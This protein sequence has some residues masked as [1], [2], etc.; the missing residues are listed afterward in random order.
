MRIAKFLSQCGIASRRKSEELIR[1]GRV[2]IN[3][4]KI[5]DPANNIDPETDQITF[6]GKVVELPD[7]HLTLAYHKPPEVIVS[8]D[9]PQGRTTIYEELP[10]E[11]Q[12]QKDRL[13]YAG[14]LDYLS[15]GL[16]ILSTDGNLINQLSHPSKGCEKR[17]LVD[18]DHQ[19]TPEDRQKCLKGV[20]ESGELLKCLDIFPLAE[21][22]TSVS[23]VEIWPG[24]K[25]DKKGN[26]ISLTLGEG[27]NRHI[28]RMLRELNYRIRRLQRFSVGGL[29]IEG[30]D[31]GE[32]KKLDQTEIHKLFEF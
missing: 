12:P 17:Y 10:A 1:A 32:W 4:Q 7:T 28:R 18:L 26:W 6:D 8:M 19:M 15:E 29:T 30:L 21:H 11:Y 24:V 14:R 31:A 13:R 23:V 5:D 20:T 16:I 3:G 22:P 25:T 2:T 9:D 27:K